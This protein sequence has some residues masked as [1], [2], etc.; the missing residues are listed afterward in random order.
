MSFAPT[1]MQITTKKYSFK[2]GNPYLVIVSSLFMKTFGLSHPPTTCVGEDV[3]EI[4]YRTEQ[5]HS[6]VETLS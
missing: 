6:K 5:I 4:F 3:S 2:Y 1:S